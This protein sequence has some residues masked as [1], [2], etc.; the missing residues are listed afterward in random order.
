MAIQIQKQY[1]L[2]DLVMEPDNH[3]LKRQGVPVSLTKKRFQV[4]VYLIER[5]SRLVSRQ[6]LLNQFWDGSEVYEE[7]LTK[8]ISEIRK[9]LND[10]K[11]PHQYIE[12]VPAVGYRYVGP[13]SERVPQQ[14]PSVFAAE[15]M[16]AVKIVVEEDGGLNPQFTAEK[17]LLVNEI[18]DRRP[19]S[20]RW[21]SLRLPAILAGAI[22]VT[23]SAYVIYRSRTHG[24]AANTPAPIR[25]IA[26]L[27]LKNLTDDRASEYFSDGMTES[28]ITALSH[29]NG[30]KVIS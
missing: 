6:E 9:A 1:L 21:R 4:L 15:K 5:R 7:N 16:R 22:I 24:R 18:T 27:P 11:K 28:L 8:C 3:V 14:E 25:S 19:Q 13:F 10:Q 29:I 12:T 26:V 23:V 30:L 2:G 20:H 17:A